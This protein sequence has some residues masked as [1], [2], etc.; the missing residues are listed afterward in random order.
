MNSE[1]EFNITLSKEYYS[2]NDKKNENYT[3]KDTLNESSNEIK[4]FHILE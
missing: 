1:I 2:N 4:Y 3:I